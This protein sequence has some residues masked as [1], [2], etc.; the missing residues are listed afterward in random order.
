MNRTVANVTRETEEL[1]RQLQAR[2]LNIDA[3]WE[4]PG[5]ETEHVRT[6]VANIVRWADAYARWPSRAEMQKRGF[7]YPPVSPDCD[8][9][10]DWVRFERWMRHEPLTWN[11]RR[12]FGPLRFPSEMNDAEIEAE[13]D[14]IEGLL[15]QRGVVVDIPETVPA[16]SLYAYLLE[17]LTNTDFEFLGP[18]T[19]CHL[20]GCTG[21]CEGCFQRPWCEAAEELAQ[22]KAAAG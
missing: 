16:R 12:E 14:R 2:G 1:K 3:V 18:A 20:T 13:V 7:L 15:A 11:F 21:D 22:E 8:P 6:V 17:E 9:D 5:G 10:S 19:Q 4:L